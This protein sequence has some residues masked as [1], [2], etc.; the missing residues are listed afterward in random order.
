MI[1]SFGGWNY[2]KSSARLE[3]YKWVCVKFSE[4][5]WCGHRSSNSREQEEAGRK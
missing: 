2:H 1:R 4:L 3:F 5:S